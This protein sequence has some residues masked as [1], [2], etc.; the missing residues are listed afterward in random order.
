MTG[1]RH[2]RVLV[3]CMSRCCVR[4][5]VESRRRKDVNLA[6]RLPALAQI[7]RVLAALFITGITLV[8]LE[9]C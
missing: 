1:R 8:A 6:Q 9:D 5:L 7:L 3:V 2:P 4:Q